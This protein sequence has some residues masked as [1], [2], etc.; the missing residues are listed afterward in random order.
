[1]SKGLL[2]DAIA[3]SDPIARGKPFFTGIVNV[4]G[5]MMTILDLA[6]FFG[7]SSL[8]P[9]AQSRIRAVE[10]EESFFRFIMGG[11]VGLRH[12]PSDACGEDVKGVDER[13]KPYLDG[14]YFL[15]GQV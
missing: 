9:K 2:V 3:E 15:G 7:Q 10:D 4:R 8:L 1:M 13:Y 12:F 6:A 14:R 5:R 11:S